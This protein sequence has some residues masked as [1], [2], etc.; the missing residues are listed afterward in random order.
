M[1]DYRPNKNVNGAWLQLLHQ[2][3]NTS[4]HTI[5]YKNDF[6]SG[7]RGVRGQAMNGPV[8]NSSQTDESSN[9]F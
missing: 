1:G 7:C 5:Q 2:P 3:Y 8:F 9:V 4:C 6:Y